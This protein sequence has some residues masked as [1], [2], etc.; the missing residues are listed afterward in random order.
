MPETPSQPDK[1]FEEHFENGKAN[2]KRLIEILEELRS[3]SS[4]RAAILSEVVQYWDTLN[5][6]AVI[7]SDKQDNSPCV[8]LNFGLPDDYV[9]GKKGFILGL[10]GGEGATIEKALEPK[11]Y[12]ALCEEGLIRTMD[13]LQNVQ[14]LKILKDKLAEIQTLDNPT[15]LDTFKMRISRI[16]L[17]EIEL[18]NLTR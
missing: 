4:E 14:N 10:I 2:L 5:L 16:P 12:F 3:E 7:K 1:L 15:L 17:T 13:T 11:E 9:S 6:G 18:N 8:E